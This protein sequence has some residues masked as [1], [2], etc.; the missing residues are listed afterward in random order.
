MKWN[1]RFL[2]LTMFLYSFG[3]ESLE[4]SVKLSRLVIFDFPGSS[5][6]WSLL[7]PNW[8]PKSNAFYSVFV[9][10]AVFQLLQD[11]G[12]CFDRRFSAYPNVATS[13]AHLIGYLWVSLF[14]DQSECLVCYT[15]LHWINPLLY[16]ITWKLHLSSP[17]RTEYFLNL[18]Y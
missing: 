7:F 11:A 10:G 9:V 8:Q 15:S 4:L 14:N 5:L 12:H 13:K 6:L 16:W 2:G 3:V 18:Y 17:I 1:R